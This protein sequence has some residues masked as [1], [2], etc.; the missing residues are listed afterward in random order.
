M[1]QTEME[2]LLWL[3]AFAAVF[4]AHL[5]IHPQAGGFR[6]A[7]R[8]MKSNPAPVLILAASLIIREG[9]NL[10]PGGF[11]PD[12]HTAMPL[13]PWQNVWLKCWLEG[14]KHFAVMFHHAVAPPPAL[15]NWWVGP[16]IQSF[17]TS[18]SQ[19]WFC[20]YYLNTQRPFVED[21]ISFRH[22]MARFPGVLILAALQY[23]WWLIQQPGFA[24][25]SPLLH[26]VILPE[27]LLFLAPFPFALAV[28]Y[29]SYSQSG[30]I[31]LRILKHCWPMLLL[32]ALSA[33]PMLTLL[34]YTL[35]ISRTIL[36]PTWM[37][38]GVIIG[39]SITAF[40]HI[41]LYASILPTFNRL[42]PR[43]ASSES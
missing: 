10:W 41:W 16:A 40:L 2:P 42:C 34:E 31:S 38:V 22:A 33:I 21:G 1:T 19:V 23:P 24:A 27:Y 9:L 37:P 25:D 13:E 15:V 12:A 43:P 36:T 39:S 11:A 30:G 6:H 3:A 7:L 35:R 26:H 32:F 17:I 28:S 29:G 4:A 5:F 18:L 8:W 20:C 14:W